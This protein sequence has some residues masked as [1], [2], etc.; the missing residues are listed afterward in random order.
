ML[1][2]EIIASN[3]SMSA[4]TE[5]AA[6]KPDN[7]DIKL[8]VNEVTTAVLFSSALHLNSNDTVQV[9]ELK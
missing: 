4:T 9:K 8:G 2:Q 7:P 6:Q 1:D 3:D 5:N